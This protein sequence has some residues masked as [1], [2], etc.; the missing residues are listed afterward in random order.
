MISDLFF[1]ILYQPIYNSLV[2]LVAFMPFHDIG[3]AVV[4]VTLFVKF[5]LFPLTHKTTKT[6]A[7]IKIIEPEINKIKEEYKDD[8]QEQSK[9]V[10]ELYKQHGINPFSGCVLFLIQF[11]II[12]ALYWVFWKGL[13]GGINP[14]QLYGFVSIPQNISTSFL[15]IIDIS[16]KSIFLAALAGISQYFQMKLSLPPTPKKE[17]GEKPSFKDDFKKSFNLQMRYGLPVLV[18]FIAYTISAV[19]ALYWLTA[20][21]FSISHELLV[22]RKAQKQA[23]KSI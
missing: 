9:K 20:N 15:G 1:T 3:L 16:D 18:F 2:F 6:Q 12:I 22:K 19:I 8:K 4:I 7:S 13:E 10:M 14:E 17:V 21:L 23:N 11:P 5:V